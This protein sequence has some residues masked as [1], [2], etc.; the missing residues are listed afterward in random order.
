MDY[1]KPSSRLIV[2]LIATIVL[3]LT[4]CRSN[5]VTTATVRTDTHDEAMVSLKHT[6]DSVIVRETVIIREGPDTVTVERERTVWRERIVH[7]T[8]RE[9]TTDTIVKTVEVVKESPTPFGQSRERGK[10]KTPGWAWLAAAIL[11]VLVA[12]QIIRVRDRLNK[13]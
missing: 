2:A 9:H 13:L 12:V 10:E 3:Y 1:R 11:A 5:S 8:V 6:I 4:S 7:D